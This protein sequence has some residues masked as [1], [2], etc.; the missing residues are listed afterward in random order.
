[1]DKKILL[2]AVLILAGIPAFAQQSDNAAPPS[3]ADVAAMEQRMKEMEERIIQL[4]GKVRMLQNTQAAPAPA[5]ATAT[6]GAAEAAPP[7][8]APAEIAATP[9]TPPSYG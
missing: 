8:P 2:T 1:M 9:S 4:E 5:T 7:A 6:P 3:A